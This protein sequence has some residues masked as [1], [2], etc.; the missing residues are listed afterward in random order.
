MWSGVNNGDIFDEP[1]DR[2]DGMLDQ[3]AKA[4]LRVIRVWVD[5]RLEMDEN[6]EPL[7]VGSYND[8][9][10]D[11]IDNLMVKTKKKGILL[12]ITLHQ[13]N[14][15]DGNSLPI[16]QDFYEWRKCKTPVNVYQRVLRTGE[17]EYVYDLIMSEDGEA[18]I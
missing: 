9:I 3:L 12:L 7:P 4:D 14:W 10:L 8:C 16:S 15:I 1:D 11:Q 5:L 2:L 18:T 13:Y 6:G 17:S